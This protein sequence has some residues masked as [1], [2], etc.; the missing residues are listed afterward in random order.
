MGRFSYTHTPNQIL[1]NASF[2][3]NY[4]PITP[5]VPSTSDLVRLNTKWQAQLKV[6]RER[7]RR[8][9][10]TGKHYK[11]GDESNMDDIEDTVVT[12]INSTNSNMNMSDNYNSILPVASVTSTTYCNQKERR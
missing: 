12:L 11:I 7:V 1:I 3:D 10:I 5:F 2:A 4:Q 8:N 9:L 6:E